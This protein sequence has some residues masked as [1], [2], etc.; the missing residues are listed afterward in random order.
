MRNV[1]DNFVQ[2]NK[3]QYL[4]ST[5]SFQ[6]RAV[7]EIMWKNL[8]EPDRPQMTIWRMS[9]ACCIPTATNILS[10]Y[11]ILIVN[12]VHEWLREHASIIR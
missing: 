10:E 7:Y 3:T 8:V 9:I 11:I 2:K 5:T 1:S 12:P 4:C 6:N